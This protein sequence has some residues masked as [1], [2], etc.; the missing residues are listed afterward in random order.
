MTA[1]SEP[2]GSVAGPRVVAF[3]VIETLFSLDAVKRRF[4][5]VGL[6][7]GELQLWFARLLRDGFAITTSGDYK[8][9]RQVAA[10]ALEPLL[11]EH[12]IEP[13]RAVEE[14]LS[15]FAELD[16]HPDAAPALR[17]VHGAGLR[18]VTLSNG[19]ADTTLGLLR[20]ARLNGLVERAISADEVKRWKPDPAPY[21]RAA[22]SCGVR[23]DQMA[24]VAVHGWDI[25]GAHRA[26]LVTGWASRLEGRFPPALGR[27]D[28]AGRTL[29]E[30][31]DGLLALKG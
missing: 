25:L 27:P 11:A 24:L 23:P 13:L 10:S 17:A 14:V 19:G 1:P 21:Q 8:P 7:A 6:P 12:G 15:G 28:I 31:V 9:F 20:R 30:V 2:R 3:D 5:K 16:P 18:V 26:G 4:T 22:A 29:V